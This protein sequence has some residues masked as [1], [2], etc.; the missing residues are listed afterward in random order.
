MTAASSIA[1]APRKNSGASSDLLDYVIVIDPFSSGQFLVQELK[2]RGEK[3]LAVR[4]CPDL[5]QALAKSW[6]KSDYDYVYDVRSQDPAR[7]AEFIEAC[8]GVPRAVLAGSGPGVLLSEQL[9][10]FWKLGSN[11]SSS[12]DLRRNKARQQE[13]LLFNGLKSMKQCYSSD[14]YELLSFREEHLEYPVV[15]KP[16]FSSATDRVRFCNNDDDVQAAVQAN[17]G[18]HDIMAGRIEHVLLQEFLEGQEY[19][20]DTVSRD[21]QHVLVAIWRNKKNFN[22]KSGVMTWE[23]SELLPSSGD[24]QDEIV[25]YVMAKGGVLDSLGIR[26]GPA[27]I[28]VMMTSN[29][30]CLIEASNRMHGADGPVTVKMCTGLGQHELAVD[31]ALDHKLFDAKVFKENHHLCYPLTKKAIVVHLHNESLMGVLSLDI[32]RSELRSVC[33]QSVQSIFALRKGDKL[34]PTKCLL[35][36]PGD[37]LLIHEDE[38]VLWEEANAIRD[39]EQKGY[40]YDVAEEF[41]ADD[42]CSTC[43][44]SEPCSP[45]SC[46]ALDLGKVETR[47]VSAGSTDIPGRKCS[48]GDL[49][50]I[51]KLSNAF[52][53]SAL[54][55]VNYFDHDSDFESAFYEIE[56]IQRGIMNC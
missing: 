42:E 37:I 1:S 12:I 49:D 54:D 43:D 35:T 21:G 3:I 50:L 13:Q 32:D 9:A 10:N 2:K 20:V 19:I 4:T 7:V 27:H 29:G 34:E 33:P 53:S 48:T 36:S 17:I 14:V 11:D 46:F 24:P 16:A 18:H 52:E 51:Q 8:Y 30:P 23:Y 26:Y 40:L 45:Q 6:N 28:E 31:A 25:K 15:I 5:S 38:N 55:I 56:E 47:S 41:D 39:L 44:I 22:V